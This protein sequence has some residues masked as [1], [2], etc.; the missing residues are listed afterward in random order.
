MKGDFSS[1]VL[2][3]RSVVALL[4]LTAL[5]LLTLQRDAAPASAHQLALAV[6]LQAKHS[7]KC[8]KPLN[9]STGDNVGV[10]Q[11]TCDM[12]VAE[13]IWIVHQ[14]DGYHTIQFAHSN[15]CMDMPGSSTTWGTQFIQWPCNG[16]DNQR[17]SGSFTDQTTEQHRVKHSQLCIDIYNASTANNAP[18]IQWECHGNDNNKFKTR[19]IYAGTFTGYAM[20]NR[21]GASGAEVVQGMFANHSSQYCGG[22]PSASWP[23]GTIIKTMNS[24]TG[25]HTQ[26]GGST[27]Y[28][29][30]NLQDVGDFG[31]TQG[32]YWADLYFGRWLPSGSCVCDGVAGFCYSGAVNSCNDAISY[33]SRPTTIYER[34]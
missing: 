31:C 6:D 4:V 15:K 27:S 5:S 34:N 32:N 33:G 18:A 9:D 13:R 1:K 24:Q 8:L 30:F 7:L 11:Y 12:R 28:G 16:G 14:S 19:G 22:D 25:F 29:T 17:F 3:W 21:Y 10:V 20:Q 2:Y 23:F 26:G